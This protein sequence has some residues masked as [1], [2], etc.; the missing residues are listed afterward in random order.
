MGDG[1]GAVE[2][3]RWRRT[4]AYGDPRSEG[5]ATHERAAALTGSMAFQSS[6]REPAG[7]APLLL[8]SAEPVRRLRPARR[9]RRHARAASTATAPRAAPPTSARSGAGR[10]SA[11]ESSVDDDVDSA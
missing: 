8:T 4:W 5:P 6:Y 3:A 11:E 1:R 9:R 7:A 2:D 10:P